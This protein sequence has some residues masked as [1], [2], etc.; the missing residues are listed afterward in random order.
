MTTK[1]EEP[2]ITKI[3]R[4]SDL[5]R[6]IAV[7]IK[8]RASRTFVDGE[9]TFTLHED[10]WAYLDNN[11]EQLVFTQPGGYGLMNVFIYRNKARVNHDGSLV[12]FGEVCFTKDTNGRGDSNFDEQCRLLDR[13]GFKR[14][15]LYNGRVA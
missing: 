14:S 6:G 11:G 8:F 3:R 10:E 9:E 7:K 12:A 5:V 2:K 4:L 13:L 15:P 1:T